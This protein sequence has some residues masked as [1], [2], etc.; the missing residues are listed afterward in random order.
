MISTDHASIDRQPS[1]RKGP[2]KPKITA[3]SRVIAAVATHFPLRCALRLVLRDAAVC[4]AGGRWSADAPTFPSSLG[5]RDAELRKRI[6]VLRLLLERTKT[7]AFVSVTVADRVARE[8][9]MELARRVL[10]KLV[11]VR[12][13]MV[14]SRRV[15]A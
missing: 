9:F 7:Y 10:D 14:L 4:A 6:A 2:Q 13:R 15:R 11:A 12:T 8:D 5:E 3:L 1:A